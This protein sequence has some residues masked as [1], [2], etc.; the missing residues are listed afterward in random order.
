MELRMKLFQLH[1][2]QGNP[3][4][5]DGQRDKAVLLPLQRKTPQAQVRYQ[6][7]N[8]KYAGIL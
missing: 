7:P 2:P 4:V 1:T 6:N 3:S 5:L 8:P